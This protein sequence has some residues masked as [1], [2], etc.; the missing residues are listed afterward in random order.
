MP[1]TVYGAG[2]IGGITGA[3]L[4][5]AGHDVLLVDSDAAH[6]GAMRAQGLTIERDGSATTTPVRAIEP[7][8]LGRDLELVLLAVKSQHTPGA[9]RE[10]APRLA[11]TGFIVSL[12]NGLNE[13]LIAQAVGAERTVGCLVNWAAD[14][15]APAASG[16]AGTA[17]SSSASW[18][19]RSP[20]A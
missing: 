12:Q 3:A 2:A 8:A 10:L 4:V 17:R 5:E 7:A 20:P 13:D 19:G 14:W 9:L 16:T 11:S 6:V 15:I 1:V 18:T